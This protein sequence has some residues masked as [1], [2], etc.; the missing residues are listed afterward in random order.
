[1]MAAKRLVFFFVLAGLLPLSAWAGPDVT[2]TTGF[3]APGLATSGTFSNGSTTSYTV[4]ATTYHCLNG[5]GCSSVSDNSTAAF[6]VYTYV[7]TF[8]V[9]AGFEPLAT[10]ALGSGA[11][12]PSLN[13][14]VDTSTT[15]A[16]V[17]V[18]SYIFGTSS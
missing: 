10:I 7:Y 1:M 16:G 13:F 9:P 3:G 14:G 2:G 4:T 15:S 12:S 5:L 8:S 17:T 18:A 11:F 6:G